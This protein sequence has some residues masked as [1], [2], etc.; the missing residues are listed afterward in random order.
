[1]ADVTFN[2]MTMEFSIVEFQME[3]ALKAQVEAANPGSS[4]QDLLDAY[5]TAHKEHFGKDFLQ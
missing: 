3:A 4:E 1:M 5:L 2:G